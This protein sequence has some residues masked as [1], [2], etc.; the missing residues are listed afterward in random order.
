MITGLKSSFDTISIAQQFVQT[1]AAAQRPAFELAFFQTQNAVLDR[2]DKEIAALQE[3]Q[4]TTG[5]TA[6]LDTQVKNLERELVDIR[7]YESRTKTND[8]N[9]QTV[10]DQI[11]DLKALA[12]SATVTE[13]DTLQK[14]DHKYTQ[15]NRDARL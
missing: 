5:A 13:F 4:L 7:D 6:L 15:Q 1:A 3:A 8:I 2:M 14:R 9:V 12:T 10:L 11:T